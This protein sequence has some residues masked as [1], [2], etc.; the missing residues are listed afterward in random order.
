MQFF[1]NQNLKQDELRKGRCV[2][3]NTKHLKLK[4]KIPKNKITRIDLVLKTP[5]LSREEEEEGRGEREDGKGVVESWR[6]G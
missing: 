1:L 3:N 5:A 2:H 6:G 4:T